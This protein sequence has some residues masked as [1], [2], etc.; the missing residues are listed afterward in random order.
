MNDKRE[1]VAKCFNV[2]E[3]VNPF[4]NYLAKHLSLNSMS[5]WIIVREQLLGENDLIFFHN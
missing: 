5:H 1:K 4:M 3:R 2:V